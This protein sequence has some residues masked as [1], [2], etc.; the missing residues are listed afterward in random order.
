MEDLR[1]GPISPE[2]APSKRFEANQLFTPSAP[3]SVA[4]MFAGRQRQATKIIDAIGEPGKHVVVY[5]ERGVGK[6]S[7]AQIVPFLIPRGNREVRHIRVQCF[8]GDTFS[9]IAKRVFSR[10]H[11]EADYGQGVRAY[12]V[13][14]F[15]PEEVTIDAFLQELRHHF[16]ETEIPVI[17]LDEF[18]EVDDEDTSITV[19]NVI[20]SLSDEAVNV[21]IIVVGVAGSLLDLMERH[22]SIERCTEQVNM[23]RMPPDERRQVIDMRL[24]KLG[25]SIEEGAKWTIIN[26]SRGLPAYVHSLGK[27]AVLNAISELRSHV[28]MSDVTTAIDEV[29]SA[30][31]ETLR[32]AYDIATRSNHARARFKPV[33]T[34]CAFARCD[35]SGFF[36]PAS[37]CEPLASISHRHVEIANFTDML[38]EFAEKRGC[39]LERTG[40]AR[41]YRFRFAKPAMQPYVLMRGIQAGLVSDDVK[42]SL[43]SPAQGGLFANA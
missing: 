31:Q 27:Y 5:G 32:D 34:A 26:L 9:T 2:D 37:V 41:A 18:N 13:V 20:K 35:D 17:V 11:F 30:S 19:S 14:E 12:S 28:T 8:P 15:Y 38:T 23:P 25:M 6:S 7:I 33:I 22:E 3:I 40:E 43:S 29:I 42:R 36:M 10:I 39:I 1:F 4:E 16:R 24:G 21:T